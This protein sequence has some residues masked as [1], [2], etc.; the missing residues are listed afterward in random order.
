[1]KNESKSPQPSNDS[2]LSPTPF[3]K[4]VTL[5]ATKKILDGPSIQYLASYSII[6]IKLPLIQQQDL[7]VHRFNPAMPCRISRLIA[8]H[9]LPINPPKSHRDRPWGLDSP[10]AIGDSSV[11]GLRDQDLIAL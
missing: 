1:V 10:S 11:F 8:D 5:F 7:I 4:S 3:C 2:A 6:E 9:L